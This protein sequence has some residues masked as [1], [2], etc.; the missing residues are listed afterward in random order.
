M[1]NITILKRGNER[2]S[3]IFTNIVLDY[4]YFSVLVR[5]GAEE[6][7]NPEFSLVGCI[8]RGMGN[9]IPLQITYFRCTI[10][11]EQMSKCVDIVESQGSEWGR[12][13]RNN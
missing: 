8:C 7:T 12:K 4:Q 13:D 11:T 5:V 10:R 3:S 9:A 1:N 2:E 6:Q